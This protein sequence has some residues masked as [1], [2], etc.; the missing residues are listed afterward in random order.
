MLRADLAD[1]NIEYRDAV[2]RDL[3]FHSL[4]HTF[5]TKLALAGVRITVAQKMMRY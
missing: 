3:D 1:A 2:G 5:C 4:R